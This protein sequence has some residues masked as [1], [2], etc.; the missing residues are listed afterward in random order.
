MSTFSNYGS[1]RGPKMLYPSAQKRF[2]GPPWAVILLTR[3]HLQS[4]STHWLPKSRQNEPESL[5]NTLPKVTN[6]NHL[7]NVNQSQLH[8]LI[9]SNFTESGRKQIKPCPQIRYKILPLSRPSTMLVELGIDLQLRNWK[10]RA[11]N[12]EHRLWSKAK[13][14]SDLKSDHQCARWN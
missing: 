11:T 5:Q 6:S 12:G 2:P 14:H 9:P 13:Q 10:P 7:N 1:N 8:P 4:F 3:A